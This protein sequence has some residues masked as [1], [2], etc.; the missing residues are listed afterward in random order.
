MPLSYHRQ[1]RQN[2]LKLSKKHRRIVKI[3]GSLSK[4]EIEDTIWE[5]FNKTKK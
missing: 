4:K 2:F 5:I 3:D 1:I